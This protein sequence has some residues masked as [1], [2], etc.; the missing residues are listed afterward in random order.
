M[1]CFLFFTFKSCVVVFLTWSLSPFP[2]SSMS[3]SSSSF[4][5]ASCFSS[6]YSSSVNSFV[7]FP[8]SDNNISNDC[9]YISPLAFERNAV[10]ICFKTFSNISNVDE[11]ANKLQKIISCFSFFLNSSVIFLKNVFSTWLKQ[12]WMK[13]C[14]S[15][16]WSPRLWPSLSR[17]Y[18]SAEGK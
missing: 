13:Y 11:L 6:S 4:S 8:A 18:L 1:F 16:E 14:W 9:L 10:K 12:M 5:P 17:Y 7:M 3:V 2:V 15:T